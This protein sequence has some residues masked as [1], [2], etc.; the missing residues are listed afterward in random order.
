[1][2]VYRHLLGDPVSVE[3]FRHLNK[4]LANVEFRPDGPDDGFVMDD[5]LMPFWLVSVVEGGVRIPLHPLLRDCLRE[6]NL[7]PC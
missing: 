5:G 2:G 6:W 3:D 7:Y 1:M 4:I